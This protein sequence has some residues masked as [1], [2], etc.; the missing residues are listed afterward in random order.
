MDGIKN[1]QGIVK[2]LKDSSNEITEFSK[3]FQGY[4]KDLN[5]YLITLQEE[6]FTYSL[7]ILMISYTILFAFGSSVIVLITIFKQKFCL[8]GVLHFN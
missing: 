2:E 8:T 6:H 1:K 4:E 5:N 3:K 7:Y